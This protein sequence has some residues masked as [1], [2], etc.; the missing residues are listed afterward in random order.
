MNSQAMF[1]VAYVEWAISV[2][3]SPQSLHNIL[4]ELLAR[5]SP[6]KLMK[7][8]ER[9]GKRR[10]RVRYNIEAAIRTVEKYGEWF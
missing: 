3:S 9:E 10:E 5:V 8:L 6:D 2:P 4:V 7:Y 1:V